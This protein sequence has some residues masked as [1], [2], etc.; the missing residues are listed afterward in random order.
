MIDLIIHVGLPKTA[1]TLVQKLMSEFPNYVGLESAQEG[2][3]LEL[4]DIYASYSLGKDVQEKLI[5]WSSSMIDYVSSNNIVSPLVV[6]SE[7]FFAG[8]FTG[9][10]EFPLIEEGESGGNLRIAEFLGFISCFLKSKF[11]V[12]VL[13][14][15]RNQPEWL[16]SKYAQAAPKIYGASQ[17]DFDSRIERYSKLDNKLWCDWGG[18][19]KSSTKS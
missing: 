6:S 10:P 15:I 18:W 5:N 17:E 14:T 8:E 4:L 2:Y 9:A 3:T 13:L 1:T 12:N 11:S 7:F 16:A 19:L